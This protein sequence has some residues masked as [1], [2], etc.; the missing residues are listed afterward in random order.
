VTHDT[1]YFFYTGYYINGVKFGTNVGTT[2][3]I[4]RPVN[5]GWLI[6]G[7][8]EAL[9]YMREGGRAKIL[10]PSRLAFYDY[11]PLLYDIHLARLVPG[12]R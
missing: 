10:C 6:A 12:P 8:D 5:E 9:T 1:A 2:D 11:E 4:R 3:T 7:F